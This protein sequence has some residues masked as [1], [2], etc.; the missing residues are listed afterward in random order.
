MEV[1]FIRLFFYVIGHSKRASGKDWQ[2]VPF[3]WP[4]M[5]LFNG[6]PFVGLVFEQLNKTFKKEKSKLMEKVGG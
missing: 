6:S 4:M 1:I 2:N 5:P 3:L